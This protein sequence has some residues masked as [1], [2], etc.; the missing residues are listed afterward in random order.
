MK[1]RFIEVN[2]MFARDGHGAK[3]CPWTE[4]PQN[5]AAA[6]EEGSAPVNL[7]SSGRRSPEDLLTVATLKAPTVM[8]HPAAHAEQLLGYPAAS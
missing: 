6:G 3:L 7:N 5:S 2:G 4:L 1:S 8:S